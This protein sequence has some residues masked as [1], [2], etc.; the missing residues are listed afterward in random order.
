MKA[1]MK[2]TNESLFSILV[3]LLASSYSVECVWK[4]IGTFYPES[5]VHDLMGCRFHCRFEDILN[6]VKLGQSIF[7]FS[8][9]LTCWDPTSPFAVTTSF[10][11]M[12]EQQQ[13]YVK[14][15][16]QLQ[17]QTLNH[18]LK[19]TLLDHWVNFELRYKFR[20]MSLCR[21]HQEQL[22]L[23]LQIWKS[24]IEIYYQEI[25]KDIK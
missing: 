3:V 7:T 16:Q 2:R 18:L 11:N 21:Y 1:I 22:N 10:A 20:E 12:S 5:S 9:L 25:F 15:L 23:E 8:Y 17:N 24:R 13:K 6:C 14:D 19:N 4:K